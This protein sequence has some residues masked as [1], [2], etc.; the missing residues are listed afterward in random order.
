M[1]GVFHLSIQIVLFTCM[2]H[3]F[4]GDPLTTARQQVND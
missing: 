4:M 2:S 3:L 1:N